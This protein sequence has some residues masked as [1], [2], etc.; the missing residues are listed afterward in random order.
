MQKVK[1]D[2]LNPE[3]IKILDALE[4]LQLIKIHMV[5]VKPL[6]GINWVAKYKDAMATQPLSDID[7]QLNKLRHGWK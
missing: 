1:I 5:N 2:I 4:Q 3:A 7:N 6:G